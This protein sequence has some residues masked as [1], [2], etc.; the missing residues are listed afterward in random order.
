[1]DS[2][3]LEGGGTLNWTAL[4][5]GLVQSVCAYLAPKLLGGAGAKTPVEGT[6]VPS[7]EQ[8]FLLKNTRLQQ[9]GEDFLLE[10][11]VE[12]HVHGDR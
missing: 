9:L 10:S 8:A 2:L 3:L 5:Q 7:P 6:G 11:E 4:E 1:M 12:Y